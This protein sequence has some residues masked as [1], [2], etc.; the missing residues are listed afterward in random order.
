M[1]IEIVSSSEYEFES[2][3]S[4][5]SSLLLLYSLHFQYY[6]HI[7]YYQYLLILQYEPIQPSRAVAVL[8]KA[9]SRTNNGNV[10]TVSGDSSKSQR[11][12]K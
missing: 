10:S 9:T 8:N 12:N 4:P 3:A 2:E 11:I 1:L 6:Y 7:H 5:S